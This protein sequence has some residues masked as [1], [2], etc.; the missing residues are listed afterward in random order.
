M[1]KIL[2]TPYSFQLGIGLV[3][4]MVSML[5]GLF[6][7]AGVVQMFGTSTQNAVAVAG[8]S[9]IQENM[10]Y[11][12]TRIAEDITQS[13][14]LG[15]FSSPVNNR[16]NVNGEP[17]VRNML[18][19]NGTDA[20]A[21][22]SIVNGD[23]DSSGITNVTN[24]TDRF[25][26]RYVNHQVRYDVTDVAADSITVTGYTA[27]SNLLRQGQIVAASNCSNGA[28][29]MI[30]NTPDNTGLILHNTTYTSNGVQNITSEKN[31][32]SGVKYNDG[33][34]AVNVNSPFYLYAGSTGSYEYSIANAVGATNDCAIEVPEGNS[35][36][37]PQHC[38]LYRS[39]SGNR[40]ELVKGVHN[41]QVRYGW[42]DA[43]G[44][45]QFSDA[46]TAAQ[47]PLIDRLEIT[48]SFNSIDDAASAGGNIDGLLLKQVT[49]T[50]NL[51]NQL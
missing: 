20:F 11:A 36:N 38:A 49:R 5:I 13:G 23:N 34:G 15:C 21:F 30:T 8:A 18:T 31:I 22:L 43:G 17:P 40:E 2:H 32:S 24:G 7:M 25:R 12:F 9:R 26:I 4:L 1:R 35:S 33:T 41:L 16:Y 28:I 19:T 46:P 14:N 3:E 42:T 39:D 48:M 37:G 29:F 44:N 10:R 50:F 27:A 47:L 45:L 51:Y 6:I